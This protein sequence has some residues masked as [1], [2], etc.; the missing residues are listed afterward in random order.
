MNPAH[1]EPVTNRENV[2]RGETVAAAAAA[3]THCIRG[4]PFDAANTRIRTDG[5]RECRTCRRDYDRLKM[6]VRR[7][8]AKAAA[9]TP[10]RWNDETEA[11]IRERIKS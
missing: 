4:H 9:A 5:A 11:R 6:R 2:L 3:K 7:A 10:M 8:A 1:L